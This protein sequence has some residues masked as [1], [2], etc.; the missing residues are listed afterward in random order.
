MAFFWQTVGTLRLSV[1]LSD[2]GERCPKKCGKSMTTAISNSSI[3]RSEEASKL[4]LPAP[5]GRKLASNVSIGTHPC[6]I[7][8]VDDSP[9][10]LLLIETM[11]TQLGYHATT[12]DNG[13]EAFEQLKRDNYD[14]VIT[15][16]YMP[17]MDGYQLAQKI[18]KT[19]IETKVILMT[20]SCKE[21][22]ID[23]IGAGSVVDGL[24]FKPFNM[25]AIKDKIESVL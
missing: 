10:L 21:D 19:C 6:R 18:K 22:V 12:A 15:D 7:L 14:V 4:S 25:Q 17:S 9:E 23:T 13:L 8:I 16:Y 3:S 2:V 5:F 24:L 11:A 20:G 1:N